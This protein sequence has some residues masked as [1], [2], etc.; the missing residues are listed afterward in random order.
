VVSCPA[1]VTYNG[2]AQTPC[3]VSVTGAG[4]LNL[5]PAP[6]YSNNMNAGTATASYTYAGDA[7]HTGSSDSKNFTIDLASS[8]TVVSC[9]ANVTYNGSAQT[10]CSVSVTGAGGLNLS[11][12]PTYANNV[13]AVTATASYTYAGDANHTGSSD[14]KNFTIDLASSTTV[15]SCPANVT[16]NGS[17]QTPC[18]VSVTVRVD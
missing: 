6:S 7:N 16:Y 2:S 11:P 9:P 17:A 3:T 12:A 15:V 18:S 5:T 8:T 4:G 1:N 10:P 13:N 14:S